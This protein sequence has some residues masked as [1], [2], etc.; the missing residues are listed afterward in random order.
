MNDPHAGK[1]AKPVLTA[2]ATI[3]ALILAAAVFLFWQVADFAASSKAL[4][5]ED[6]VLWDLKFGVLRI[7]C[8][9]AMDDYDSEGAPWHAQAESITHVLISDGV[10]GI[11][12]N[13][14][15]LCT[16]LTSV[17]IP[18]TVTSIGDCAFS[19]CVSLTSIRIPDSVTIIGD[20]AFGMCSSLREI[21]VSSDNPSYCSDDGIVFSKDRS[22]LIC[23]P[24]GK[25]DLAYSIPEGVTDIGSH[26]FL[27]CTN[28]QTVSIPESMKSIGEGAFIGCNNL[29]SASFPEGIANIRPYTFQF[30]HNLVSVSIPGS[31]T[32]IGDNVFSLCP[33][34][35]EI[36]VAES[37]PFFA[38]ENGILFSRDRSRLIRYPAGRTAREYAIPEG[39]TVIGRDAF[40]GCQNL[41]GIL[42]PDSVTRIEQDA[43]GGCSNLESISIPDGVESIEDGAFAFCVNLKTISLP[44][45]LKQIKSGAFV[46][47]L[48]LSDVFFRGTEE[49]WK[50]IDIGDGNTLLTI[51]SIHCDAA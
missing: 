9:G 40:D 12:A 8:V 10:T 42:I 17:R 44:G 15:N 41:T 33:R 18:N 34:L 7:Y 25:D 1:T 39:V 30:C 14:F 36:H 45:K 43:F 47:C 3:L 5:A 27:F 37:N 22:V 6:G 21:T 19:K 16:R 49:Q 46:Y 20:D 50:A 28:L 48:Q 13:A 24:A 2:A 35:K 23:F 26:A 38:C 11:G 31:V 4:T 32:S 29:T 51:A